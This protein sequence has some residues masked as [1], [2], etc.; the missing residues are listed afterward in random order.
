MIAR[1]SENAAARRLAALTLLALGLWIVL[2]PLLAPIDAWRTAREGLAAERGIGER[3]ARLAAR[4]GAVAGLAAGAQ[5]PFLVAADAGEAGSLLAA[6]LLA[7]APADA[8]RLEIEPPPLPDARPGTPVSLRFSFE[9]TQ[10]A[11]QTFLAEIE[12]G[13]PFLRVDDL[14]ATS[15]LGVD[16]SI[17]L[18]GAGTVSTVPLLRAA[19]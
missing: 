18:T 16:G 4:R 14:S 3:L 17:T 6:R 9:A 15:L 7:A 1:L 8:M 10:G 19:R 13:K 11:F 2:P 12:T 5:V